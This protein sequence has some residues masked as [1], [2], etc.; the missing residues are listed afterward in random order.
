LIDSHAQIINK[1]D[2]NTGV[3]GAWGGCGGGS[4]MPTVYKRDKLDGETMQVGDLFDRSL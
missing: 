1:K 2:K 4:P 3:G